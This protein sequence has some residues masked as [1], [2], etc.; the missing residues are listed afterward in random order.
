VPMLPRE[1][2]ARDDDRDD[3][4]GAT[5][6]DREDV[7]RWVLV[8]PAVPERTKGGRSRIDGGDIDLPVCRYGDGRRL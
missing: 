6:D 7:V 3:M 4:L 1:A 8:V 5:E 2:G